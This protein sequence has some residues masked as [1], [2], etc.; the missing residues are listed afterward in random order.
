MN[1]FLDILE[2]YKD[3]KEVA[4]LVKE[5]Q[6]LRAYYYNRRDDDMQKH[7]LNLMLKYCEETVQW[8]VTHPIMPQTREQ[9]YLN[10]EYFLRDKGLKILIKNG[11]KVA[12]ELLGENKK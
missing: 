11:I 3:I 12:K 2:R 5:V 4:D 1:D 8:N 10:A 7:I 6:E 9:K